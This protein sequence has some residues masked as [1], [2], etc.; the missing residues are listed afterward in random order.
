MKFTLSWLK[1]HLDTDE[2]LEK[3]AEKLTM[4]GLEVESIE[5]KAKAL[6][7]FTIA[8]VISAEQHPN[9]DRLRVCMVDTGDGG[10]PVQV[11]CGAPN[12][13]A[14]LVSVFSP[15]GTYIPGK[16]ITLGI[17]TIRGVESRGMLCSAA[18]L[19][20]SNDHDGIMELPADAPIG[21]GYAEWA[22][23]G[24]PV[25][26]I[27]LT[28]NRQ[29][30]TG[31]HG[32]ARDLAA[33]DMGKFKDPTIK[34]IKGEFPCPVKV[35]VEDSTLCPGFAL[36]LVRGVKNG[37]SPEWL[38]K[39]LTAIGLRPINALV[40]ITNFMTFDR[41]RPLHVFDAKKV[42]GNL[43]VRRAREGES[44]LAL[45]GRTYNLDPSICVIADEHGVESLAGIMGG[46]ASGCDENTTDVL[47]ESA[48]W[49]EIN[50][51]QTGR[52][53]GINSDAR[54][55]F[56]RGVDPAFMVPGIELATKLVMEMCG[57]A[58][59]ETVVVGKTFGDDR[60]IEF[61]ITEVKRL[62]GIE[63]PQA[64]MKRILTH[65]GFMMAGPGPVVKVAV[66]SWRSDVH[67]KADIV[68]EIVRIFGVDKVPM[69]PFERGDDA[70]KPV[71]TSLQ[72]RT[73]R[74]RRALASRGMVA[75]V[76]WSFIAKPAA[77]LFGGGPRA[78]EVANPIASDLSDMRP[79][80]LAGLIAAAQANADRGFGDV[81]LFEVGQLFKG[82]RPQDQFMA[83][84]G[85]RR[86]LASSE[87]LGRHWSG[88][89]QADVFDAKADALAV[90]AASGAP[91]Q[92]LQVVAGGPG[93]LHPGRSGT[94][95]IGPQNVLGYFGEM[96]P[97]ALET[98]GADGPLMVFEV[99]LD[100]IPEAKK[101]PTRAKP[102]IE[103]SAFQPVSRD[104]A[105]IV[106]RSVKAG[107]IV[108]A[109]QGI[110]KKLITGV[111]V[112]DVYEGKGIDEGKKSIAIAVT[113]QPREKTLTDQEI[114]AVGA[115][116]VAEVTKKT[117]GT[118]RA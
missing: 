45:D 95:Q 93:W 28:P 115:K 89:A 69:T 70:R 29:D 9:A 74:A 59:S 11:V 49:N 43:V 65:L 34:P 16:D 99:I 56:E 57:G 44:L 64:E 27:N 13:R 20:I 42:K 87:G 104:F 109:A 14:G 88:S 32:I 79:T 80:L 108:R 75:A 118:L 62:S 96:H 116:I 48:L 106:D 101:K 3:L 61:P 102:L 55:R 40:D 66:P 1:D 111:N 117:G 5:N 15:P 113:L 39:R 26:E 107:D 4:I 77:A 81:A 50:I 19:Q 84:S 112:F 94:I 35:N 110:D 33:A 25:V 72:L 83:A 82:D 98:L 38:Q 53:L 37:P 21:A 78:L 97:R 23:L 71:L 54:Y 17:G 52:K 12:A 18:E 6:K 2:P 47:I 76:T 68:E 91:V 63:V 90:L 7:A 103:L 24:D 10:A 114:E 22:A 41:A 36:R 86:G 30:C 67:G 92:A 46:E 105:F 73:R 58:P 60:L 8:K 100:R 85:V 51:A 31:V